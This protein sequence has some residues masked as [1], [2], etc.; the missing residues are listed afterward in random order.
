[1]MVVF[2]FVI[3]ALTVPPFTLLVALRCQ[4][5]LKHSKFARAEKTSRLAGEASR[6]LLVQTF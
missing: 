1:M 4:T 6:F 3:K 5:S 2:R